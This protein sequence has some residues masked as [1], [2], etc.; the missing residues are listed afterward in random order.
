MNRNSIKNFIIV[1]KRLVGGWLGFVNLM[2]VI[3]MLACAYSSYIDPAILPWFSWMGL[4]FPTFLVL[5]VLFLIFWYFTYR[6]YMLISAIGMLLC[7]Q[8]VWRCCPMNLYQR[9]IPERFI[10]VLSYNVMAFNMNK[11]HEPLD[12]NEVIRYLVHCDADIIC[13]QEY[14]TGANLKRKEIDRAMQGYTYKHFHKLKNGINGLGCYSRYPILSA[15]PVKYESRAN[16][17][18]VYRIL[19]DGDTL[20]VINNHLESNKLTLDDKSLY[21]DML[22]A[23]EAGKVKNGSRKLLGKLANAES[24]RA[25]QADSIAALVSRRGNSPMVVCGDFNTTPFSYTYRVISKDLTDAF[26]QSGIGPGISYHRNKF[27]FRIDHILISPDLRSYECEVD[28]S[29]ADSDHYPIWCLISKKTT[30]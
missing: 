21:E 4:A 9:E 28:R 20:T 15:E 24:I 1:V 26:S 18:M 25:I 7:I 10:K 12:P 3:G 29:I 5:N 27:Y 16:G 2:F 23:P 17:S 14:I 6:K 13:L 19:V 8:S 30:E 11:P 22:S